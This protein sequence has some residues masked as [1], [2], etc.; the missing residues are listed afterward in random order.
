MGFVC[1]GK[2]A[3]QKE[4]VDKNRNTGKGRPIKS[5]DL[6]LVVQSI[7]Q[8]KSDEEIAAIFNC[9]SKTLKRFRKKNKLPPGAGY[10]GARENCEK[11]TILKEADL[12][13]ITHYV[14]QGLSNREIG[15]IMGCTNQTVKNFRDKYKID[16]E[17]EEDLKE[18]IKYR[19]FVEV[20]VTT[21]SMETGYCRDFIRSKLR[22]INAAHIMQPVTYDDQGH[23]KSQQ[24]KDARCLSI[25][26]I[27]QS[28]SESY[29]E[30]DS[31]GAACVPA[32]D[33]NYRRGHGGNRNT[34]NNSIAWVS[35][36]GQ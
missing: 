14:V 4:Q 1:P 32:G 3:I 33:G 23:L 16:K 36:N 20:T 27:D 19:P 29:W 7:I 22:R 5:L 34:V 25:E 28:Q 2:R 10:G 35:V 11:D 18:R 6:R 31:Q 12:T 8:G 24:W 17:I 9:S 26:R 13:L 21:L 30:G 15:E